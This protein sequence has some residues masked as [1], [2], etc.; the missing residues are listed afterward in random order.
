MSQSACLQIKNLSVEIKTRQGLAYPVK[1]LSL[2]IPT[3]KVVGIVGESGSGK[4]LTARSIL[5]L[6]DLQHKNIYTQGEI[7]FEG[8]DLMTLSEKDMRKIRGG[9]ISMVFQDP[10]TSLNPVLPIGWQLKELFTTHTVCS[11]SEAKHQS[12]DMLQKVGLAKA[13]KL[14]RQFPYQLSGGMRQRV[15]I[16]MA[17][18]LKPKLVIAD[19]PTTALDVTLQAQILEELKQLQQEFGMS[20]LL[21]SHD[22]GVIAELAD[23]VAVMKQGEIVEVNDCY[24]LFDHPQHE[25]T[26]RLMAASRLEI[27]HTSGWDYPYGTI[28]A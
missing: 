14:Y 20:I 22:M 15:M 25:Y 19:E 9:K 28:T 27:L 8:Q 3:G 26:Q 23:E 4:S 21:I 16:A 13:D 6:A 17:L 24:S 18:A 12:I 5:R 2:E 7:W 1:N 10:M 11:A